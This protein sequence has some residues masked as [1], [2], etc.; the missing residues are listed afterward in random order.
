MDRRK[1]MLS[2]SG[3]VGVIGLTGLPLTGSCS[4]VTAMTIQDVIEI[5][6]KSVPG[7]P[8]TQTVDTVKSGDP[9][10]P[11]TGVVTT[12]FATIG[13]IRKAIDLGA[14]LIIAH[15]PTYYNHL[16][17]TSAL[18]NDEVYKF[19]RALLE[20]HGIVVWRCHDY[21]HRFTADGIYEGVL[22]KLGW[23]QYAS[24]ESPARLVIPPASL[25][26]VIDHNKEKLG[27]PMLRYM[28]DLPA[29]IRTVTFM[30]GAPGGARQIEAIDKTRPDLVMIGELAEWETLEYMRDLRD[31][32]G[33]TSMIILGH[34]PSEEPG[35]EWLVN[36]LKPS[37]GQIPIQFISSGHPV[38]WG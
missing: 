14:N 19:K 26:N 6:I 2:V 23:K 17:N 20:Q 11:V 22:G 3:T 25:Q 38:K 31:S 37:I 18:V 8:L 1:F 30:V 12:M 21:I 33:K 34:I 7:G 29:T 13:V 36:W 15:E 35:M 5:V 10:R 16:D 9:T 24:I 27:I 28:G 4:P 32:G